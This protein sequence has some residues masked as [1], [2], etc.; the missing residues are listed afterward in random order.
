MKMMSLREIE[1]EMQNAGV[2]PG[3]LDSGLAGKEVVP[4]YEKPTRYS[5][6]KHYSGKKGEASDEI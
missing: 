6:K 4:G 2:E 1:Q 5:R 3:S